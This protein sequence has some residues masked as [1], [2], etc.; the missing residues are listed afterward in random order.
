MRKKSH[1]KRLY[2]Q[3]KNTSRFNVNLIDIFVGKISFNRIVIFSSIL[4]IILFLFLKKHIYIL[5]I[6]FLFV[7]FLILIFILKFLFNLLHYLWRGDNSR[8][9]DYDYDFDENDDLEVNFERFVDYDY[10]DF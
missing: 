7:I 6:I 10:D 5:F 4:F 8:I 9:H 3:E 2:K 1:P